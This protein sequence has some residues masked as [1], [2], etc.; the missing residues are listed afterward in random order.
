IVLPDVA[1]PTR[2]SSGVTFGSFDFYVEAAKKN[3]G[4]VVKNGFYQALLTIR[5]VYDSLFDL[6]T[7][8]YGIKD[9]SGPVGVTSVISSAAKESSYQLWYIFVLLAMNLGIMNMLPFPALD[10]GRILLMVI[11]LIIRR[12]VNKKV[13]GYINLVGMAILLLFMAVITFKDITQ[14]INR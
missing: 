9:M 8:V 6:V 1:F 11:E 10:G 5:S 3:I 12:P 7:G 13:E 14:L 2:V 4:T